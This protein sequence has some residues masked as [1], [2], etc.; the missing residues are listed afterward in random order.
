[1][2][3][4]IALFLAMLLSLT[5]CACGTKKAPTKEE[6]LSVAVETHASGIELDSFKN[7]ASAKQ[8]YC[9]KTLLLSGM[10]RKIKEDYIEISA[11]YAPNYMVDVYLP[12]E[13]LVNLEEGQ[14]ITVVGTTTDEITENSEIATQNGLRFEHKT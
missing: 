2:K 11:S 14:Y 7:I 4:I 1:M 8:K 9:N 13:E 12:L 3:K 10:V 5:L 6:M